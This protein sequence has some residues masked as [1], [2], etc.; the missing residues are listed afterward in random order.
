MKFRLVVEKTAKV[1]IVAILGICQSSVEVNS[2]SSFLVQFLLHRCSGC[3]SVIAC[4]S[5]SSSVINFL[6]ILNFIDF[7]TVSIIMSN[8]A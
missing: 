3:Q 6:L 4:C 5:I 8:S 1:T 2:P 7:L